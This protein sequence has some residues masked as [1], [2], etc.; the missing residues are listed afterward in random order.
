VVSLQA[1]LDHAA[2]QAIG[3]PDRVHGPSIPCPQHDRHTA[4]T[5]PQRLVK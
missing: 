4:T 5:P 2:E 3:A 1:A